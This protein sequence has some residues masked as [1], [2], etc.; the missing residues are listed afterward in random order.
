MSY[1]KRMCFFAAVMLLCVAAEAQKLDARQMEN[2]ARRWAAAV[3]GS[4]SVQVSRVQLDG[5]ESVGVFNIAGGGFVIVSGDSRA[6]M[7]LG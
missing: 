4:K 5:V 2:N 1:M 3:A 7:V 6:R